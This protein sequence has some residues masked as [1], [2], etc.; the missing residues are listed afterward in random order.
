MYGKPDSELY[1]IEGSAPLIGSF[2]QHLSVLIRSITRLGRPED[3]AVLNEIK[4]HQRSFTRMD[5]SPR[6]Q[7]IV[8]RVI[9]LVPPAIREIET[10]KPALQKPEPKPA[11]I[12]F[13][14]PE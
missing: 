6:H 10:R 13:E 11:E 2:M 5:E 8:R 1:N 12:Q 3:I 14:L 9:G 7:A 4:K